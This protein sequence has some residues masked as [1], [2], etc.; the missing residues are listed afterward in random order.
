MATIDELRTVMRMELGSYNKDLQKLY[1]ANAAAARKVEAS[2]MATNAG[3]NRLGASMA[4]N[5]T[6]PLAG[7]GAALA[8]REVLAYADAWTSAKNSLAVAG[9]TGKQQAA[10]LDQ[11]YQSA[12]RN[13]APIGAMADLFGKAAQASDNLG[14]SQS[15]LLKFSDGVGIALRVAGASAESASGALTQ[16]GQ[17]LGSARVQAE[18]FNS[19]NEGAR[20]I[21]IAVANGL[22]EAGGSVNKLKQLVNDGKV[23]GQQFF[24]AFLKGMP[25]VAAMAAG[26]TQTIDQGITKVRNA[27]TKY[28]GETDSS[29]GASQ[30]LVAGLNALAD[31]FDQVA[32]ATLLFAGLLA[33]GMLGR[34]LTGMITQLGLG[35][36][37]VLDLI[38]AFRKV[39]SVGLV[40]AFGGLGAALGPVGALLG[41]AAA[42]AAMYFGQQAVDASERT[43]RLRGEMDELGISSGTLSSTIDKTSESIKKLAADEVRAKLK[44]INDELDHMQ[45]RSWGS[46]FGGTS[47]L[48]DVKS[49][50]SAINGP[51]SSAKSSTKQ[52]ASELTDLIAQAEAGK[53]SLEEIGN[54]LDEISKID[55]SGGMDKYLKLLREILPQMRDLKRYAEDIQKAGAVGPS[56]NPMDRFATT[57]TDAAKTQRD[58][59]TFLDKETADARKSEAQK[60]IDTETAAVMERAQKAGTA[61]SEAAARL[62]AIAN[63]NDREVAQANSAS[64]G[65]ASDLIKQYEGFR[66]KPYWDV[67]AYRVGYGSDTVTLDD[68]SVQKVTQGITVSVA[69]ANRDLARRVSEF[70]AGVRSKIGGSTFDSMS[71]NQ[72]AVLTSIAY[73]YGSLPDRIVAAIKSGSQEQVYAAI[74]GLGGDNGGINRVRRNSEAA[75][76]ISDAPP[77]AQAGVDVQADLDQRGQRI[78]M[79]KAE[80]EALS[81]LNPLVNDYGYAAAFASE[82]QDILNA[83]QQA[84]I[85]VTPELAAK[86]DELAAGYANAEV[87]RAKLTEGQDKLVNSVADFKNSAKDI[88]SGFISDLRSGKSAAEALSNAL[89]KIGDKMLDMSLNSLFGV[90]TSGGGILSAFG[91]LFGLK[92]SGGGYTGDGGKYAPAGVVHKGEYV[93]DQ[94]S[95]KAA[96]GPSALD[97]VR[98]NLKGFSSGGYVT[99]ASIPQIPLRSLREIPT[100]ASRS[101]GQAVD[102]TVGVSADNNGNLMP[103]VESV[104]QR[105]A[106]N[107]VGQYDVVLTNSFYNRM[108]EASERGR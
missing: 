57:R 40:Q 105:Q 78:A 44:E 71:T 104:S 54:R 19:V 52:A 7:I 9:V 21:L 53:I 12:Q 36:K 79:M 48:G 102:V 90:G 82:K 70:Q 15:D 97:A 28:I 10:V 20:P 38:A 37:G 47:S 17:L 63:I 8:T 96:G 42:G 13:A 83:V 1:G 23:S 80:T 106:R 77:A 3:L 4:R 11:L 59:Q 2:W 94:A 75:L 18:E 6:A 67:N 41:T 65:S 25:A 22:D 74:K 103:F 33:G 89:G 91:G 108:N 101:A 81:G 87:E 50:L 32:D 99:G 56:T 43:A 14:A 35:A 27:L 16:L 76:Y 73:N 85:V 29:L 84:G 31:N 92:F 60:K 95:V 86:I 93:F 68:G 72:Q 62:Q 64:V 51:R 30:R 5:I 69:D 107:T 26:S 55:A 45:E 61:L 49:A 66:A 98:K 34:S 39:K 24:Q 100:P 58:I 88:T 46:I